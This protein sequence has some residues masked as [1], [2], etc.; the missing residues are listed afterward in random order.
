MSFMV[1]PSQPEMLLDVPVGLESAN[2][3]VAGLWNGVF[4]GGV[5][6]GSLMSGLIFVNAFNRDYVRVLRPL[7]NLYSVIYDLFCL[8]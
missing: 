2:I 6:F 3:A 5:G 1:I 7:L 8:F 4:Q